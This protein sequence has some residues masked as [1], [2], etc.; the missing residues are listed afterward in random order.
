MNGQNLTPQEIKLAQLKEIFPE[1]FSEQK[2]DWEKLKATLGEDVNFANERYV[3]NWAGKSDAFKTLQMPTTK[4]L[5]PCKEESVD[6]DDTNNVFIEGENLEV[7]KILQKSYFGKVKMIYIDPPYNT[8]KDSFVYPDKFSESKTD[9]QT[10]VGDKDV[11]GNATSDNQFKTNSKEN[12]QYHSNWLNMMYPRLFLAKNLLKQDGVIFVS[13]D[14]NEVHNL[15]LIMDEVFGEDN[16]EG[17][18]H[19]RRRHNQP[20]DKTKMIGLV[21][22]HILVY[23]KNTEAYKTTGVG[24]LELTGSFS[25]PDNDPRGE[26]SSKPWKTGSDQG[27]S[28]YK[29]IS[30]TGKSYEE[31]WMGEEKTFNKLLEDNRIIFPKKGGGLP[32]KKYYKIEREEEGQSATNWW[33]HDVFGHNQEANDSMTNLF[34]GKKNIFSNPKSIKL[35][36]NF[37]RLSNSKDKQV[38][39]DFFA[40][41]GTTAHAV[42]QLNAK[43]DGNRQCISVQ[44]PEITDEKSEAF[45]AG[46][47]TI[48][49]ISKERIRRAGAKIKAENPAKQLDTG[50]K[51]FKLADSNFKQ[52]QQVDGSLDREKALADQL[53]L[54]VDPVIEQAT[55]ENMLVELMLKSGKDLNSEISVKEG[56]ICVNKNELI[57]MLE[58]T[59]QDI[60]NNIIAEAP[61]KVIALDR[62]FKNDDQLKTNTALQMK[63]ADIEFKT[64]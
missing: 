38:V 5:T 41:S 64:V 12:G 45:K 58:K 52:W 14:D 59:S 44:L 54:F 4:T 16:F 36:E 49:D 17:H 10:R 40:G 32:R 20:N 23:S 7:L 6:F 39:L 53:K 37:I 15:R 61:Q 46:Y 8:G 3:L 19:W 30:P 56:Y 35:V 47:Q 33:N 2:V 27:G 43:D 9:Y 29:I 28:S 62:L 31:T 1:A 48:A 42:M 57:F 51:V 24:K 11:E 22:E 21:A 55:T 18:I 50:F 26:W 25:N 63:D 34:K 13:I 60:V